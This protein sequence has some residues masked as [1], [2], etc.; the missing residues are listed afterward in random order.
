[1]GEKHKFL[2]KPGGPMGCCSNLHIS[3]WPPDLRTGSE[4]LG[5]GWAGEHVS[6]EEQDW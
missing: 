2:R 1:M 4:T 5:A 6:S 3:L